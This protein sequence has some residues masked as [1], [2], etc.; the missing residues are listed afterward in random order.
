[1]FGNS[2]PKVVLLV[3]IPANSTPCANYGDGYEATGIVTIKKA[4]R[5]K[6]EAFLLWMY[7][8]GNV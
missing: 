8:D 3:Q 5:N 1:M 4:N 6:N 2:T 7:G